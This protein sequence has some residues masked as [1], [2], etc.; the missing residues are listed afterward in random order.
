[1][2]PTPSVIEIWTL[3]TIGSFMIFARAYCR[4]RLVGFRGYA[5]DDY[6]IWATW[7]VY[8][9][10]AVLAHVF[11]TKARGLHTS[12]LTTAEREALPILD[13]AKWIY[14]SK[15]FVG[16]QISY[17]LILW[18]LKLNM[19]FFYRRI[20]NGLWVEKYI[21][22]TIWLVAG[23]FVVVLITL[24]CTCFPYHKMW[25]IMPD[26]GPLCV[27]LNKVVLFTMLAMNLGTDLCIVVIP[28]PILR[29]L[30]TTLVRKLGLYFV[31]SLGIFV[32]VAAILRVIL[33]VKVRFPQLL[34][35][36]ILQCLT[37]RGERYGSYVGHPR[38]FCRGVRRASIHG[39]SPLQAHLL[40]QYIPL[41]ELEIPIKRT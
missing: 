34:G 13:Y 9:D 28:L 33:V 6:L 26:P 11:V 12:L 17:V 10:V 5:V 27:P 35:N 30:K 16:G 4:T 39:L 1:M 14:G 37:E 15:N 21:M 2:D 7:L 3:Y 41:Q 22:P 38:R 25:Q 18:L 19:L 40:A 20:T 36:R 8:T 24:F 29:S 23:S 32:M 31:F